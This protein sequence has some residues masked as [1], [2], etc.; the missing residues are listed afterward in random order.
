MSSLYQDLLNIRI[1]AELTPRDIYE[2]TR[3]PL[4]VISEIEKGTISSNRQ[5]QL[6]YLRSYVR[7]YAKALGVDD[8]DVIEAL[9]ADAAGTYTGSIAKRYLGDSMVEES[10]KQEP[11]DADLSTSSTTDN[12]SEA[13]ATQVPINNEIDKTGYS[14]PDPS[15]SHNLKTPAPPELQAVDW[16]DMG[17][18]L[19][20]INAF[21][22]RYVFILL[23]V[24]LLGG[25]GYYLWNTWETQESASESDQ[26]SEIISNAEP[27]SPSVAGPVPSQ[28]QPAA[29]AADP[30]QSS[31]PV[32]PRINETAAASPQTARTSPSVSMP[33]TLFVTVHAAID[34]LEPIRVTS[35]VNNTRSPYWVESNEAMRFDFLNEIII[36][37][38]LSRMAIWINGHLF[39]D[40]MEYSTSNRIIELSRDILAGYPQFFNNEPDDQTLSIQRPRAIHN[41]PIF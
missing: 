26:V 35:D 28:P 27:A 32:S 1:Q 16:S 37:G 31:T 13:T 36:E 40:F 38:Q 20:N 17:R 5:Y 2:R 29:P 41:R 4:D 22:Y 21:P 33:D 30:V 8:K 11:A 10:G 14:R 23:V 6:T 39:E 15:K 3:I 7:S 34:R 25:V 9:D 12:Y 19:G 18:K 24:L